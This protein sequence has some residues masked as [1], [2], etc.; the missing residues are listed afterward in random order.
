MRFARISVAL[1]TMIGAASLAI[2]QPAA[3]AT[4]GLAGSVIINPATF[5]TTSDT[6]A[7]SCWEIKQ[8]NPSAGNGTYWLL[9]PAMPAPQQFYCDQTTDGGGWVLVGKGRDGWDKSNVGQGK[10][11]ALLSPDTSPMSATTAQ[12][13]GVTIDALLNNARVDALCGRSAHPPSHGCHRH[14]LAGGAAEV[15]QV[16]SLGLGLR[17]GVPGLELDVHTLD[18][19]GSLRYRRHVPERRHQYAVQPDHQ[20]AE[21]WQRLL[22]RLRLRHVGGR[23]DRGYV[24][25]LV[26]HGH[27]RCRA[28]RAGLSSPACHQRP[29]PVSPH[30]PTGERPRRPSPSR[31]RVQRT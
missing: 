2:V 1:A 18:G 17:R 12:Y 21:H 4:A 11:S 14:Q 30:F 15:Q 31:R 25:P 5:G 19:Y 8:Q 28:L 7:G 3:A 29:T 22:L 24:V 16:R 9:T 6:A 20:R 27:R 10:A 26:G 23:F 13:D